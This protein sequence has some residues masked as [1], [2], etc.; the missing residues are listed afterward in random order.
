MVFDLRLTVLVLLK[1]QLLLV[2]VALY[3]MRWCWSLPMISYGVLVVL[4]M[5]PNSL[6]IYSSWSF[7]CT[8]RVFNFGGCPLCAICL[9]E[10]MHELWA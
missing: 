6:Y 3:W 7:Y 2:E 8:M 1:G 4:P 5:L 10:I 9:N